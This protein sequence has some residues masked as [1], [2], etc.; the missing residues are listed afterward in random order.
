MSDVENA[1]PPRKGGFFISKDMKKTNKTLLV[2]QDTHNGTI[3]S[4]VV[5]EEDVISKTKELLKEITEYHK[6]A[7]LN[8]YTPLGIVM[9]A[10]DDQKSAI[11]YQDEKFVI[12]VPDGCATSAKLY[13]DW[14]EAL[15]CAQRLFIPK[16]NHKKTRIVLSEYI[17]NNA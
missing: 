8:V 11:A 9:K 17:Q 3:K 7:T 6:T 1:H 10:E 15:V 2:H 16:E 14:D 4:I 5:N 12:V 13:G